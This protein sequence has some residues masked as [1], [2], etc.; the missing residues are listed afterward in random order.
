MWR[1]CSTT[2]LNT[3][4]TARSSGALSTTS[5]RRLPSLPC[6]SNRYS[7]Y[8]GRDEEI[9]MTLPNPIMTGSAIAQLLDP[10]GRPLKGNVIIRYNRNVI[11]ADGTTP[12]AT[13]IA[14]SKIY[15]LDDDGN[16]NCDGIIL[17]DSPGLRWDMVGLGAI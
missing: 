6:R 13:V 12:P 15:A 5:K 1:P 4:T 8:D 10:A 11:L 3:R 17:R 14:R 16:V 9:D 7:R 2:M